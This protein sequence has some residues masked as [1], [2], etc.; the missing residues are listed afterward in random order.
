MRVEGLEA[1]TFRCHYLNPPTPTLVY[2]Q[3]A[4]IVGSLLL[5]KRLRSSHPNLSPSS[6][7]LCHHFTLFTPH[8]CIP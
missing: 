4:S 6:A 1:R 5:P 2:L 3:L 7:S 8:T